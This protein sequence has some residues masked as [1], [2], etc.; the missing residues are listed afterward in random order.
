M[1]KNIIHFEA[2]SNVVNREMQR[3]FIDVQMAF[4]KVS[5]KKRSA[6]SEVHETEAEQKVAKVL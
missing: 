6:D 5:A 4:D 1:P 2:R 3:D